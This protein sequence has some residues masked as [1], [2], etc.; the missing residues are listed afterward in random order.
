MNFLIP[1]VNEAN[2]KCCIGFAFETRLFEKRKYLELQIAFLSKRIGILE[3]LR[4]IVE[5]F[6]YLLQLFLGPGVKCS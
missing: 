3:S 6:F 4:K 1:F 2:F 5:I